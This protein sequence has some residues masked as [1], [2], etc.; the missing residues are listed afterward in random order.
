MAKDLYE[1]NINKVLETIDKCA[2]GEDGL[3][4]LILFYSALDIMAWL[5]RGQDE[6][7]AAKSDFL[8][9]VNEFLLPGS[10][11]NCTAEDLYSA[12]N[13]VMHSYAPDWGVGINRG[14][15]ETGKIIY[16]WDKDAAG[17]RGSAVSSKAS[18]RKTIAVKP[19]EMVDALKIAVQ[20]FEDSLSFNRSLSELVFARAEKYFS[21]VS[22]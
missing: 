19:E 20:R 13:A 17:N 15:N 21:E 10:K 7:E 3:S 9:W 6:A 18:K 14:E 4:F 16:L 1:N 2:V 12:R 11:L 22:K 8:H 5:S